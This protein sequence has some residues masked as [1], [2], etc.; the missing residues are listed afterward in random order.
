MEFE[1]PFCPS[2][3][4]VV[5]IFDYGVLQCLNC[6]ALGYFEA[7]CSAWRRQIVQGQLWPNLL[8]RDLPVELSEAMPFDPEAKSL[9]AELLAS[10]LELWIL[11]I[12]NS[13]AG[14]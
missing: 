8:L 9:L 6:K 2:D 7:T 12:N 4:V 10:K 14:A 1:I 13:P 5:E 11:G 3:P